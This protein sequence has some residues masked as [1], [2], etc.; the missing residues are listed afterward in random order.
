[1]QA[2]ATSAKPHGHEG[3]TRKKLCWGIPESALQT[4]LQGVDWATL[5]VMPVK[6]HRAALLS[7]FSGT[8]IAEPA[9]ESKAKR[10]KPAVSKNLAIGLAG[11]STRACMSLRP[12]NKSPNM[13]D[14]NF[15]RIA[16]ILAALAGWSQPSPGASIRDTGA[17]CFAR[18]RNDIRDRR[19]C[20]S[21]TS[22]DFTRGPYICRGQAIHAASGAVSFATI[23]GVRSA[24]QN[25]CPRSNALVPVSYF[26]HRVW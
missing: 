9:R 23:A 15:A 14:R 4:H 19:S 18:D 10:Q 5:A 2:S 17:G 20:T 6:R 8:K 25:L 11:Q 7:R 22:F 12:E 24:Q 21:E 13:I 1:M 3:Q 26:S 16:V